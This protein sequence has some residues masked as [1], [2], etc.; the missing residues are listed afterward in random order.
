VSGRDCKGE[1]VRGD[2]FDGLRGDAA[3]LDRV[4]RFCEDTLAR[5]PGHPE[6]MNTGLSADEEGLLA[7]FDAEIFPEQQ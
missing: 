4:L 5:Q 7:A 1:I 2:F 3:A 6:A